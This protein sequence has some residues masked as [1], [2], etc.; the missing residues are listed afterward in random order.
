MLDYEMIIIE[1]IKEML[2]KLTGFIPVLLGALA[3]LIIGWLI[4]KLMRGIV[5]RV[6]KVV[7]FDKMADKAGI[8]EILTKG[9]IKPNARELLSSLFYWLLMIMVWVMVLNSLGLTVA[10]ELLEKIFTY[11]PSVIAAIF[12]LILGMFIGNFFYGI[13]R[14]AAS[15]AN[16]P[17]PEIY[18]SISKW[19]VVIFAGTI[20]LGEL[21]IAPLFVTSTFNI[22]FG[23]VCLA[24]ALAFGLGGKDIATKY[25]EE[26]T[27]GRS[28]E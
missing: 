25:L 12:V 13:T 16:L 15:N 18:G 3:I 23:A 10:A 28:K 19:A 22:F 8:A 24:L 2:T 11:L 1:P 7:Q 21:G 6:L 4:A 5:N 9:G 20:A 14:T 17:K 27:K 26:V